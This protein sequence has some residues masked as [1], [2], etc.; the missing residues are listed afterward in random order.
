MIGDKDDLSKTNGG[1]Q[2]EIGR[3][4]G[5]EFLQQKACEC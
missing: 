5:T 4:D 2:T 1:K 3:M